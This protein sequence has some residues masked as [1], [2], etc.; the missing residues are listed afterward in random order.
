MNNTIEEYIYIKYHDRELSYDEWE[1]KKFTLERYLEDGN[2]EYKGFRCKI[3][4]VDVNGM[5]DF[6]MYKDRTYNDI[7]EMKIAL[8]YSKLKEIGEPILWITKS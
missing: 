1:E 8:H 3:V 6:Y 5:V 2:F 7:F 4:H